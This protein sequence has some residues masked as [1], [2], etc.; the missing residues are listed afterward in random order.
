MGGKGPFL[1]LLGVRQ[2]AA[3]QKRSDGNLDNQGHL[4]KKHTVC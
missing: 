3:M 1:A 4:L 2:R